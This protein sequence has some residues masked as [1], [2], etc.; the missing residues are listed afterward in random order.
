MNHQNLWTF[1]DNIFDV[2]T[3]YV[4]SSSKKN[5]HYNGAKKLGSVYS[6]KKL[7]D[8]QPGDILFSTSAGILV[9][10]PETNSSPNTPIAIATEYYNQKFKTVRFVALSYLAWMSPSTGTAR[11]CEFVFGNMGGHVETVVN[12]S[13]GGVCYGQT[14]QQFYDYINENNNEKS[15]TKNHINNSSEIYHLP[16]FESV[17]EYHT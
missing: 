4:H 1:Y 10:D 2:N 5:L 8:V 13:V 15:I 6:M 14:L 3:E 11:P 12:P 16:V 7:V 17:Y 9:L